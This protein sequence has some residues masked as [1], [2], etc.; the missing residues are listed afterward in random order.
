MRNISNSGL[1]RNISNSVEEFHNF[2]FIIYLLQVRRPKMDQNISEVS[3][4]NSN[5]SR[6]NKVSSV[7]G[8]QN[9]TTVMDSF[10][11]E[12]S[13]N[14][15][16]KMLQDFTVNKQN[17]P[18]VT[19]VQVGQQISPVFASR[20]NES[21]TTTENNSTDFRNNCPS[22][23][24]HKGSSSVEKC[25]MQRSKAEKLDNFIEN[26]TLMSP[27][28][29]FTPS[30]Q[31]SLQKACKAPG[32]RRRS[33]K[34]IPCDKA[35]APHVKD[36]VQHKGNT[37]DETRAS[38]DVSEISPKEKYNCNTDLK[39]VKNEGNVCRPYSNIQQHNPD[40]NDK[41]KS[42]M[43]QRKGKRKKSSECTHESLETGNR[44]KSLR[45]SKPK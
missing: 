29:H 41:N 33:V 27:G 32:L 2:L 15:T 5:A 24:E 20:Q 36:K 9:C 16:N 19:S 6:F 28:I 10:V 3:C 17:K 40:I 14:V 11:I 21:I 18:V 37:T 25:S 31:V 43:T 22:N 1:L 4:N 39:D 44:R 26:M 42:E 38:G 34:P 35:I 8:G 7:S 23:F 30:P 13:V 45:L 12:A